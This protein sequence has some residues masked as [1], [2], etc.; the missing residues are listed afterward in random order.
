LSGDHEVK[1]PHGFAFMFQESTYPSIVLSGFRVPRKNFDP[2]KEFFDRTLQLCRLR[3]PCHAEAEFRFR[4]DGDPN[5][6]HRDFKKPLSDIGEV[7]FNDEAGDVGVEKIADRHLEQ[8]ALLG[9]GIF[10]ICEKVFGNIYALQ[11]LEEIFP[12]FGT[13]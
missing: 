3:Q 4:D 6:T 8:A 9:W 10:A 5:F 12:G 7:A 11:Q 1:V 13:A 2:Q